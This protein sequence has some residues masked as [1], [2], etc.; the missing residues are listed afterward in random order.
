MRIIMMTVLAF[1]AGVAL[2]VGQTSAQ[3][4]GSAVAAPEKAVRITSDRLATKNNLNP[5]LSGAP[6]R[7]GID[8]TRG[9]A[10]PI[11]APREPTK[12]IA[13]DPSDNPPSK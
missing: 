5:A 12:P 7:G 4:P 10:C 11:L 9:V 8:C 3:A 6:A 1:L 2:A 13:F